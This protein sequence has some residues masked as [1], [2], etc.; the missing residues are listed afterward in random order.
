[1]RAVVRA[2]PAMLKYIDR[3]TLSPRQDSV[4]RRRVDPWLRFERACRLRYSISRGAVSG[5]RTGARLVVYTGVR[6]RACGRAGGCLRAPGA[7]AH[8]LARSRA[9]AL[10]RSR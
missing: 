1:M 7:L 2:G 3:E 10:A 4:A 9:R 8:P 6:V 5:R